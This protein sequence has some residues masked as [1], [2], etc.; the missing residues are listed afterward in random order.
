MSG[1]DAAPASIAIA[2]RRTPFGNWYVGELEDLP[3]EDCTF[4]AVSGFNSFQFATNPVNALSEARRVV[5][6]GAPVSIAVWG[7]PE[8]CQIQ[9]YLAA[10][11]DLMPARPPGAAGPFALS[12]PGAL[13]ALV[14][15]AGLT[16][17]ES[18]EADCPFIYP[19]LEDALRGL[20]SAGPAALAIQHSRRAARLGNGGPRAR[21]VQAVIRWL[22]P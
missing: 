7:D 17:R 21:A 8:Q 14:A 4:D 16:P 19:D 13:E 18:A 12:A 2:R 5:R 22:P 9:V 20:L 11:R 1:V 3:F 15:E 6:P 10:L